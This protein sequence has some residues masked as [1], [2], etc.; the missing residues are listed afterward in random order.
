MSTPL[1]GLGSPIR[2][3]IPR[4][5]LTDGLISPIAIRQLLLAQI[6]PLRRVLKRSGQRDTPKVVHGKGAD[7]LNLYK[8]R[9]SRAESLL[10]PVTREVE[11][12][13]H[14]T[15]KLGTPHGVTKSLDS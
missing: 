4:L 5:F 3:L 6:N 10:V 11:S 14:T 13:A 1:P 9:L 7:N 15:D 8:N 2:G 12:S